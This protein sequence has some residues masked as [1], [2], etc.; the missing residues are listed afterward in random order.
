MKPRAGE[1]ATNGAVENPMG[2]AGQ[3]VAPKYR[4]M[5]I[6]KG[7]KR[8]LEGRSRIGVPE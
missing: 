4:G 6:L 1:L 3:T 7:N 8:D 2:E 5:E